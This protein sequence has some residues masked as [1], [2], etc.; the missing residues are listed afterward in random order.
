VIDATPSMVFVK[1]R[2]GRFVLANEAL[3]RV[4]GTPVSGLLGKTDA[5]FDPNAEEVASFLLAD[6]EVMDTRRERWIPEEPVTTA[7]GEVR[8]FSTVKVPLVEDDG[9]CG[10]VLGVATDHRAQARRGGAPP[11]R[12]A[13]PAPRRAASSASASATTGRLAT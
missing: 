11:R 1:D 5:D 10:K 9:S 6:R 13:L 2:D 7:D 3:A 4:Y 12:G 8:W